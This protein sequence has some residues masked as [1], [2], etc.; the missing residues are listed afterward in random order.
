[1]D[2]YLKPARFD[3]DPNAAGADKHF[4][5]WLKTFQ[6]FINA[7][8]ITPATPANNGDDNAEANANAGAGSDKKLDMCPNTM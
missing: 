5:H 7:I 3:C 2:K 1:M 4:K 8:N 6:N